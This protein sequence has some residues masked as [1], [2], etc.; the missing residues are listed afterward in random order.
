MDDLIGALQCGARYALMPPRISAA[1]AV[2]DTR[3]VCY[4]YTCAGQLN[5]NEPHHVPFLVVGC[6]NCF[7]FDLTFSVS[8][9]ASCDTQY[10]IVNCGV[11]CASRAHFAVFDR[12]LNETNL[13]TLTFSGF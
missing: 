2:L 4:N 10:A 11:M 1:H 6:G 12:T 8:L 9:T 13:P 7:V 5:A 3:F